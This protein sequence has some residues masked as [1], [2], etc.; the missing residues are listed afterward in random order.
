MKALN[1]NLIYCLAIL[2]SQSQTT[3]AETNHTDPLTDYGSADST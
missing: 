2:F 1:K 3:S